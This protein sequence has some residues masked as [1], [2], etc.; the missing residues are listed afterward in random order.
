VGQAHYIKNVA[1]KKEFFSAE[2]PCILSTFR[3]S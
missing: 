2:A 3:P 1:Y